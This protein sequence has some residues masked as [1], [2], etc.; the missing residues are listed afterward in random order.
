MTLIVEDGTAKVNAESYAS[1]AD[2]TAYH[3]ARGREDAWDAIEDQ[4]A[5]LRLATQYMEQAYRMRWKQFRTT[6]TQALSW[7]RAWVQIP[8]APY[9]YGSQ[10]AYVPNNVV[11]TE[12]KQACMELALRTGS[13]ELAPDL[14][15]QAI[16]E[17]IGPIRVEYDESSSYHTQYRSVDMM[18]A[19]YLMSMGMSSP[20][21]R[22]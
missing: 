18:L 5:A 20:L 13:G 15:R 21:V 2:A 7:P 17:Q 1:V 10:S 3:T 6:S 11:P 14:D 22:T 8:D 19:P 12:V 9:G 16:T 4:E